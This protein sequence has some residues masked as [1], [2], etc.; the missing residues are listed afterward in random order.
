MEV[1]EDQNYIKTNDFMDQ[2]NLIVWALQKKT[3]IQGWNNMRVSIR[4]KKWYFLSENI[5][6]TTETLMELSA[7]FKEMSCCW[8]FGKHLVI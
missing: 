2:K 7:S 3:G 1:I 4:L 8:S 5:C 6:W